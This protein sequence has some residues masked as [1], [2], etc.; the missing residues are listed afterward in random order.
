MLVE[1]VAV[2]LYHTSFS[3]DELDT[4]QLAFNNPLVVAFAIVPAV[5]THVVFGVSVIAAEQLSF[6]GGE[7]GGELFIKL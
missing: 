1:A 4:S 6:A 5:E 2:N 7:G 3:E